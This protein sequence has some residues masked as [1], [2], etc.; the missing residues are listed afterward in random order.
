M[1]TLKHPHSSAVQKVI[2][3]LQRALP[4]AK[5]DGHLDMSE[6][7]VNH[8]GGHVCGTIHCHGGWFAIGMNMHE[9]G[10]IDYEYGTKSMARILGFETPSML[11]EWSY[12]N[13]DIW[14]NEDGLFMF[15]RPC[16]FY[17]PTRR[18]TGALNLQ[19]IIDHWEEVRDRLKVLEAA[20]DHVAVDQ[21]TSDPY[22]VSLSQSLACEAVVE[23]RE[24]EVVNEIVKM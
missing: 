17:H 1:S 24:Q 4:M 12:K 10:K 2:D 7:R 5:M 11:K 22:A 23:R 21:Q 13:K 8:I 14:N 6:G 19:H 15:T 3:A 20:T 16:A 9:H 18:P